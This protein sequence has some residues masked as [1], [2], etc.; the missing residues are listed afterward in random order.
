MNI[1]IR[2]G[3]MMSIAVAAFVAVLGTGMSLYI[4]WLGI[5]WLQAAL[6]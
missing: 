3:L 5:Q 4:L 1:L 6:V 2:L